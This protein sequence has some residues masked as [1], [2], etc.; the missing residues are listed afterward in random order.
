MYST[1]TAWGTYTQ[2]LTAAR[3]GAE[4]EVEA[5]RLELATVR[6]PFAR[7]K[8]QVVEPAGAQA[9]IANGEA[10]VQLTATLNKGDKLKI[11]LE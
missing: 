11:V 3:S 8:A 6:L 5:G 2:A 9:R 1:G 7:P 4:I 10:S